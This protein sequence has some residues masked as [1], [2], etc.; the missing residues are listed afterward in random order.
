MIFLSLIFLSAV[1]IRGLVAGVTAA[2]AAT[3]DKIVLGLTIM[4][5]S[6]GPSGIISLVACVAFFSF[7]L[8][9]RRR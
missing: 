7:R 5:D 6:D 9:E 8:L 3:Y 1:V 2:A 4:L